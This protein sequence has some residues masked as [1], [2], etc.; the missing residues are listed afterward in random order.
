MELECAEVTR[1]IYTGDATASKDPRAAE[2]ARHQYEW[3]LLLQVDTDD[4]AKMMWGDAG[5]I[6]FWIRDEDLRA[7]RFDKTWLVFQCG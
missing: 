7:R 5:R 4:D 3:R 2:A 6:Y 1:G